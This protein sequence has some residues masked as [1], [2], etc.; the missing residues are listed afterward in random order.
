MHEQANQSLVI[1]MSM[2]KMFHP[3][4]MNKK[5]GSCTGCVDGENKIDLSTNTVWNCESHIPVVFVVSHV[6]KMLM[7][8]HLMTICSF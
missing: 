2:R 7:Q 3:W 1:A 5:V 6:M 8:T 4:L